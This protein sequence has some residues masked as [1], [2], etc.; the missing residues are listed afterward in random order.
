M[1]LSRK[2]RK[3]LLHSKTSRTKPENMH[4]GEEKLSLGCVSA[5]ALQ[6]L[7]STFPES[8]V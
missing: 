6:P 8:E 4:K 1:Q 2:H 3:Y 5:P 7:S